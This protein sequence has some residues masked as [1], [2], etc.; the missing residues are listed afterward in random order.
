MV[1]EHLFIFDNKIISLFS[2]KIKPP[3]YSKLKNLQCP[4]F[5]VIIKIK[6]GNHKEKTA[7]ML[8]SELI[9]QGYDVKIVPK[10]K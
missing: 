9:F 8:V 5:Y 4:T 1:I 3:L 7:F 6:L 10:E 2:I